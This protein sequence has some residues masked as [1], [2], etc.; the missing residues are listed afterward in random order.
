GRS[1]SIRLS[2]RGIRE[3]ADRA[4]LHRRRLNLRRAPPH[5]CG[6]WRPCYARQRCVRRTARQSGD[7]A[8]A[9]ST[10]PAA[11]RRDRTRVRVRLSRRAA[12]HNAT[13]AKENA[14]TDCAL[15]IGQTV[16]GFLAAAILLTVSRELTQ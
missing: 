1:R 15:P 7:R 12:A 3:R 9:R 5:L 13:M 8:G 10:H 14:Q 16:S 6:A 4:L 2:A 11:P